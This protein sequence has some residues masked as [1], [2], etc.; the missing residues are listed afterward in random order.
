M[1]LF[2]QDRLVYDKLQTSVMCMTRKYMWEEKEGCM[3]VLRHAKQ[4]AL[5]GSH[6][7]QRAP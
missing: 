3:T 6:G 1:Q 4:G 5:A 2:Q 7:G